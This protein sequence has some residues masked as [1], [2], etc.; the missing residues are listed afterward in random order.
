[1]SAQ[2]YVVEQYAN[3]A[4]TSSEKREWQAAPALDEVEVHALEQSPR[5]GRRV[6][7]E[8]I[9]F[10]RH[11]EK[12]R[13]RWERKADDE[14]DPRQDVDKG[15]VKVYAIASGVALVGCF[16]SILLK[17]A[18]WGSLVLMLIG[19]LVVGG[20]AY[21]VWMDKAP[22]QQNAREPGTLTDSHREGLRT[23]LEAAQQRFRE[24]L[25]QIETSDFELEEA[26]NVLSDRNAAIGVIAD[27]GLL[28]SEQQREWTQQPLGGVRLQAER[29]RIQDT[30]NAQARIESS[31]VQNQLN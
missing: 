15:P 25:A 12:I 2:S 10:S 22:W 11:A 24:R 29:L 16:V 26:T 9:D 7:Q 3:E 8:I 5:I 28:D 17:W 30:P 27:K 4:W 6:H 13:R 21:K 31:P 14:Y 20:I 19:L 1:M 18:G 23:E